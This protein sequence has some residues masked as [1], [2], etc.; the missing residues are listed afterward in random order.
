M[1]GDSE[2]TEYHGRH[3]DPLELLEDDVG[4]VYD[5]APTPI[6]DE[7]RENARTGKGSLTDYEPDP[8]DDYRRGTIH[9]SGLAKHRRRRSVGVLAA[10]VYV[11]G[12]MLL[13][14]AFIMSL[15]TDLNVP[16][17]VALTLAT[18]PGVCLVTLGFVGLM[19]VWWLDR[20]E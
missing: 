9:Y 19:W 20:R 12:V 5:F 10:Y 14:F 16:P 13:G 11:V 15:M 18:T 7:S 4:T 17:V 8:I 6:G 3:W 2:A 1:T